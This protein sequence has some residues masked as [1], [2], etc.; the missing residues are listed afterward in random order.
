M[1]CLPTRF[2]LNLKH[3][4]IVTTRP[5]CNA[6]PETILHVLLHCPF[7]QQCCQ[8]SGL[9]IIRVAAMVFADWTAKG[10]KVWNKAAK[11]E[12]AM[13]VGLYFFT[14]F[15][16]GLLTTS[17]TLWRGFSRSSKICCNIYLFVRYTSLIIREKNNSAT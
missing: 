6:A 7:S 9:P 2:Q 17:S 14:F 15:V 4:P 13:N 1:N 10:L 11:L 3:E 5:F 12:V 8:A 16:N